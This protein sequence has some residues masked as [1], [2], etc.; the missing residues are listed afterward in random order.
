MKLFLGIDGGQ[1][2]IKSVLADERGKI[3]GTGSGGP[4]VHF[5]DEAARQQARKSLS[6]AIQEPLRQAG[7]PVTQ[8]I[9]SAFLGITGVNG[10]ESPAGRSP[11]CS[12]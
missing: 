12:K 1:T 6:Q 11:I 8:E 7:F 4:A 2:S 10:P 9:E 3:L 5:A